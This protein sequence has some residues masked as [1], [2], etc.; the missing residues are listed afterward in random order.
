MRWN[1]TKEEHYYE[2][3][4]VLE[5]WVLKKQLEAWVSEAMHIFKRRDRIQYILMQIRFKTVLRL[6]E[7]LPRDPKNKDVK[8]LQSIY[9]KFFDT[10]ADPNTPLFPTAGLFSERFPPKFPNRLS[11]DEEELLWS[12]LQAD[13]DELVHLMNTADLNQYPTALEIV[14]KDQPINHHPDA[15]SL[16]VSQLQAAIEEDK[17]EMQDD[18]ILIEDID[19]YGG[20]LLIQCGDNFAWYALLKPEQ[21]RIE[22]QLMNH[23]ATPHKGIILSLREY[24]P[25]RGLQ[26][27]LTFEYIPDN[28]N[29]LPHSVGIIG[30]AKGKGNNKPSAQYHEQI[31]CLLETTHILKVVGGSYLSENN[32][33]LDDLYPA[34]RKRLK[35]LKPELFDDAYLLTYRKDDLLKWIKIYYKDAL[36]QDGMIYSQKFDDVFGGYHYILNHGLLS[37][38][39]SGGWGRHGKVDD[40]LQR[41]VN[42]LENPGEFDF[43]IDRYESS[44]I[45]NFFDNLRSHK[46]K[47]EYQKFLELLDAG[48]K[49]HHLE[50]RK[51]EI[52][53]HIENDEW[54]EIPDE[55]LEPITS[56]AREGEQIGWESGTLSEIASY[57]RDIFPLETIG[58]LA[59]GGT[60]ISEKGIITSPSEFF[61]SFVGSDTDIGI[62]ND[63]CHRVSGIL[64]RAFET[65]DFDEDVAVEMFLDR[66]HNEF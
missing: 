31:M 4:R 6:L 34:N 9:W 41:L 29:D 58:T 49:K 51:D 30:E 32:F 20:D 57:L 27:R 44:E 10:Y 53:E 36:I 63:E 1:P 22:A 23:C 39:E 50:Q 26:P 52:L 18:F 47:A 28:A 25:H 7:K 43:W 42:I 12:K 45:S 17:V 40:Q 54:D 3:L 61:S 60:T 19:V 11:P 16:L 5:P 8:K 35:E 48:I 62:S 46:R 13:Y 64:S 38:C 14:W 65:Q 15:D 55:I 33:S 59:A 2:I 66:L 24:V 21:R 56:A 37:G